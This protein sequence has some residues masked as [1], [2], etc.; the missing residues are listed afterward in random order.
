MHA[1]HKHN[2]RFTLSPQVL[3]VVSFQ[4]DLCL[5]DDS[6]GVPMPEI[7]PP[8]WTEFRTDVPSRLILPIRRFHFEVN[9]V[10][11]SLNDT[12]RRTFTTIIVD[13]VVNALS[14]HPDCELNSLL[15]N[16]NQNVRV[17]SGAES[18][19]SYITCTFGSPVYDFAI[20]AGPSVLR[21][22]K[23]RSTMENL[24][25]TLPILSEIA[26]FLFANPDEPQGLIA[27][28]LRPHRITH[29]FEHQL[30]LGHTLS[31][32]TV[33]VKN[34][35]LWEKLA[36]MDSSSPHQ[37]PANAPLAV[38]EPDQILRG[39]LFLVFT[40]IIGERLRE[41]YIDYQGPWNI[42]QRDIDLDCSYRVGGSQAPMKPADLIDFHT[43]TMSFY[44]D[45]IIR[46]LFAS[47]FQD[48]QV[49]GRV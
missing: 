10:P 22:S 31:D 46:R 17:S 45:L 6:C 3:R 40:K 42:T 28:G 36:R 33:E 5:Y 7:V 19:D 21:I 34:L 13:S 4:E 11:V 24:I 18:E 20:Q 48:I 30:A 32:E 25:L 37:T 41:V 15:V 35:A 8:T 44:R 16:E 12:A 39:D 9:Y 43:P 29:R 38:L 14:N 27:A 47:L 1:Q 49:Q 2:S 23:E 26:A